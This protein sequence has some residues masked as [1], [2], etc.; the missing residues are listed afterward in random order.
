[1][2]PPFRP[3]KHQEELWK[4]LKAGIL[5]TTATDN[6]TF[7]AEQKAMGRNDFTKYILFLI[8]MICFVF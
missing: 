3:A 5:Q 6:C 7:C 2:S 1:M 8:D 4:G